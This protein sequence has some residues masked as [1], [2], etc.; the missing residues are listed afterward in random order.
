MA[1]PAGSGPRSEGGG[2]N[3]IHERIKYFVKWLLQSCKSFGQCVL[4][5]VFAGRKNSSYVGM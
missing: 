1:D 4:R 2:K 5:V 3:R